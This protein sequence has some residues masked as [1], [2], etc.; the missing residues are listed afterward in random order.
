MVIKQRQKDETRIMSKTLKP[1]TVGLCFLGPAFCYL[2]LI[3]IYP[4]GYSLW[5]SFTDLRLTTPGWEFVGFDTYVSALGNT[6]F[7][8]SLV[9]TV[10]FLSS[11][12]V[13]EF[14]LGFGLAYSFSRMKQ[15][16]SVMR[17]LMILPL[18]ATPVTVG[19]IWKLMLN[20]DFGIITMLTSKMGFGKVLWLSNT[21]VAMISVL[22]MDCW[23]WMPFMFLVLLAG[24]D[25][26]PKE[27]FESAAV[28]GAGQWY[29]LFHVTIPLMRRV[30]VITLIFR[31]MFAVAT[32]DSVFVL[33]K[34]GPARATD[35]I[36][37]FLFRQGFR[38][39]NIS[40]ASAV[41]YLLLIVIFTVIFAVFRKSMKS[42]SQAT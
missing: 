22:F 28:D 32:F 2:I 34:G 38:N 5:A 40:F 15:T 33:T 17:A 1:G 21:K 31:L 12:V 37:L 8:E 9:L 35:L 39:M 18:M 23:N 30:I 25:G 16:H 27:P 24:F 26:L 10:I 29:T 41:S 11:A 42:V 13:I 20:S 14:I 4:M 7:R 19:L 36:A 6:V 3:I